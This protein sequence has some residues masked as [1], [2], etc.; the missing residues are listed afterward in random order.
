MDMEEAGKHVTVETA[1]KHVT[2]GKGGKAYREVVTMMK[3]E[4]YRIQENLPQPVCFNLCSGLYSSLYQLE[5][6]TSI[7]S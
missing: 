3:V 6:L 5:L 4:K 1:E 7:M 2:C